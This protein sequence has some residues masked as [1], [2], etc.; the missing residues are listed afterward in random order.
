[1]RWADSILTTIAACTSLCRYSASPAFVSA[2]N[3]LP[4]P[5][6][7]S[8]VVSKT[9]IISVLTLYLFF[10]LLILYQSLKCFIKSFRLHRLGEM[11]VESCLQAA[12][13]VFVERVRGQSNDRDLL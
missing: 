7:M 5:V 8:S 6:S 3:K 10:C 4:M 1:M 11:R 13:N 9:A 2:K 12:L